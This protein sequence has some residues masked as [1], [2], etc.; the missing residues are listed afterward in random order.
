MD[1]FRPYDSQCNVAIENVCRSRATK[2]KAT[3][4]LSAVLPTESATSSPIAQILGHLCYFGAADFETCH[5]VRPS[6]CT[7]HAPILISSLLSAAHAPSRACDRR[8]MFGA[9]STEQYTMLCLP[10]RRKTEVESSSGYSPLPSIERSIDYGSSVRLV[11]SRR[12]CNVV[13]G[14]RESQLCKNITTEES[15]TVSSST[16]IIGLYNILIYT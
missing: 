10:S 6:T 9:C 12:R 14:E 2:A 11:G 3:I 5:A 16:Q 15:E 8:G 1:F 4:S 7:T 13:S